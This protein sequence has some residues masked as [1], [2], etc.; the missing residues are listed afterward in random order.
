[1]RSVNNFAGIVLLGYDFGK[2]RGFDTSSGMIISSDQVV[3]TVAY[4][5][6]EWMI[7]GVDYEDLHWYNYFAN[8]FLAVNAAAPTHDAIAGLAVT[9]TGGL[10]L[11]LGVSLHAGQELSNGL[12]VGSTLTGNGSIP[13]TTGYNNVSPGF[14]IGIAVDTSVSNALSGAF[15][16]TSA[17]SS[18]ASSTAPK[19]TAGGT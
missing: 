19:T 15:K 3:G 4:V 16:S 10:S 14:F 5:G 11:A 1:M 8:L 12:M 7:G 6:A 18:T 2:R 9:P 17:T 13:T